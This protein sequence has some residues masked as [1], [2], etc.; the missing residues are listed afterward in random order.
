MSCCHGNGTE[1][2]LTK[3]KTMPLAE[4]TLFANFELSNLYG[5]KVIEDGS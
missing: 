1:L 2:S 5:L 4:L 3:K